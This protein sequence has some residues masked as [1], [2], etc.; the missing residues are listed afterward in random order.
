M[1]DWR[2]EPLGGSGGVLPQ[3]YF[4]FLFS[5]FISH[6]FQGRN[7][8]KSIKAWKNAN[9]SVTLLFI[10]QPTWVLLMYVYVDSVFINCKCGYR[11][12]A[13]RLPS[14][15]KNSE[16]T[17]SILLCLCIRKWLQGVKRSSLWIALRGFRSFLFLSF[18]F[19]TVVVMTGFWTHAH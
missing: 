13:R 12:R 4:Y 3:I 9:Y 19:V 7:F 14:R 8:Q 1:A 17:L 15:R 5:N 11:K 2:R 10:C 18:H 6:D 16:T